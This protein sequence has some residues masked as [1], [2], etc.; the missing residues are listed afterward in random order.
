MFIRSCRAD[1]RSRHRGDTADDRRP[2]A[3]CATVARG[4]KPPGRSPA[5]AR[6]APPGPTCRA[7]P[8]RILKAAFSF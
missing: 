2:F 8:P 3:P 7:G 5:P 1:H 4:E 6:P